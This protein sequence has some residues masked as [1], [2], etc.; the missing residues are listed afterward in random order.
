MIGIETLVVQVRGLDRA[1]L[2]RWIDAALVRPEGEPGEWRFRDIDVARV[3][4]IV[5]LRQ[6]MR[7]EEPTLPL[8]LSLLDQLYDARRAMRRLG[9]AV[10]GVDEATR[11]RLRD[12]LTQGRPG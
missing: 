10:A 5:E 8:V 1:A 11:T 6:E 7:V 12:M 4:L 9:V 3:R 2:E